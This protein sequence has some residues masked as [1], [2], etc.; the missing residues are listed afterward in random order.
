[1]KYHIS[2]GPADPFRGDWY[3]RESSFAS[4]TEAVVS[5]LALTHSN[6]KELNAGWEQYGYEW[7]VFEETEDGIKKIWEG[8]KAIAVMQGKNKSNP[9]VE[10]GWMP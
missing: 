9:E 6:F 2:K 7:S 8:Y 1:M 4:K 5:A 3:T 10:D